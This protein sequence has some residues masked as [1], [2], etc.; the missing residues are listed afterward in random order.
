MQ[1]VM[2]VTG[3]SQ[4]IG[5]AVARMAGVRGYSVALTYQS[6]HAL[7]D[8]VVA[9]ITRTSGRA[10]AV[11]AEMADEASILALFRTVDQ[12]FGP[13]TVLVNNAGG[14][15]RAST[16]ENITGEFLDEV[17]AVNV[18]AP[19]LLIREAAAR[20]AT[21]KGGAGG[22]IVNVSSRAAEIGGGGEWGHY[23]APRKWPRRCCGLPRTLR[24]TS[25]GSLSLSQ[26]AA[27]GHEIRV[28]RWYRAGAECLA[29]AAVHKPWVAGGD[30]LAQSGQTGEAGRGNRWL[31]VCLRSH[32]T[33]GGCR[34]VR[35]GGGNDRH[36]GHRGLQ[37]QCA[38]EGT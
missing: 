17:L 28:D 31:H 19:F 12:T 36:A 37:R 2:I 16:I 9:D 7:A 3:G 4:G 10:I 18:R 24:L 33:G 30:G 26:E 11:R 1:P 34:P 20:M 29:G 25:P 13:V 8:G 32:R 27:D 21:D 22:A 5:A 38:G 23:A 14:P 6:N 35:R 15:G